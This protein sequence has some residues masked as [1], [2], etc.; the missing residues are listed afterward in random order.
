[1]AQYLPRFM[2]A[3]QIPLTATATLTGGQLVLWTGAVAGDAA[4]GVAGVVGPDLV[5]GQTGTVFREGIH[6]GTASGTIAVGDPLC[7]AAGGKPRKW[8]AGTDAVASYIAT[9]TSAAAD[10]A[11]VTYALHGV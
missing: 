3:D 9:A 2:D 5:S 11:P 4:V 7:S 8:I 10:A 6:I 1:M